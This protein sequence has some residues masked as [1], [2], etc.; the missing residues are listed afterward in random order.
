MAL[1]KR[2]DGRYVKVI[3][4]K[5]SGKKLS[6]YGYSEREVN[7]KILDYTGKAESG[8]TFAEVADEW[9]GEALED[10]TAGTAKGYRAAKNR[11]VDFFGKD[12]ICEITTADVSRYLMKLGSAKLAKATVKN[13]KI[14]VNR[15]F[16]YAVIEGDIVHNPAG[17]A[18]IP[19]NLKQSRRHPASIED[20]ARIRKSADVWLLPYMALMTGM[21]KGELLALQWGDVDFSKNL[22]TVS[23]SLYYAN[24]P[25]IKEPKTE[26]GTRKIPIL[27]GLREQLVRCAGKKEEF[28]FSDN[29]K[30]PL[31]AKRFL[32]LMKHY[33]EKTG[34]TATLHQLRKSFATVAVK[35]NIE[36]KVLQSIIGH[37]NISTTLDIY[38]E[39]REDSLAKAAKMLESSELGAG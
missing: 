10:I 22:I 31:S 1:K 9:W 17:D 24:A 36:P 14:V 25:T 39:V 33:K 6:F 7:R 12:L 37:K 8:R 21:R 26:A 29:G 20:E 30:K 27:K 2:A 15:I 23:K 5:K 4:D 3:T 19:R 35:N 16:H 11:A 32:T 18:E 34:V 38:A 13:H 28:V